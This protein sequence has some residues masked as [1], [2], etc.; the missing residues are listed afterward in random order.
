[1]R[2]QVPGRPT[3]SSFAKQ[4]CGPAARRHR[5]RLTHSHA[6]WRARHHPTFRTLA[7]SAAARGCVKT[8]NSPIAVPLEARIARL[9]STLAPLRCQSAQAL[10]DRS[11]P[12]RLFIQSGELLAGQGGCDGHRNLLGS[13]PPRKPLRNSVDCWSLVCHSARDSS[14]CLEGWRYLRSKVFHW[15]AQV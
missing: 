7:G 10:R 5:Q 8:P 6:F 1:M 9:Q 3:A 4:P 12:A 14:C 2:L 11:P 13:R 15:Y